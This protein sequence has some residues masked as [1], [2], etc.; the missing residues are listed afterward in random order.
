MT[1]VFCLQY[2]YRHILSKFTFEITNVVDKF[3][4]AAMIIY[5]IDWEGLSVLIKI[6]LDTNFSKSMQIFCLILPS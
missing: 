5:E 1:L 3:I 2:R 4:V 6:Q